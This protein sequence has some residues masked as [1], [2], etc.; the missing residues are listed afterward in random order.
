PGLGTLTSALLRRFPR[1]W[2]IEFDQNL[3]KNLP[4]SFPGKDL[5]VVNADFL[6]FDLSQIS[7]PYVVAGNIPYYITS[8]IIT[9]LLTA[10]TP[11]LKIVLL[12]QKEV[13]ERILSAQGKHTYLSI[14]AQ[15]YANIF[16]GSTVP[17][18]YFTPPPKVDSAV[19]VFEPHPP[20]LTEKELK[21]VKA[22]FSNPRKKLIKN[23]PHNREE[24]QTALLKL[25]ISENARPADLSLKNWKSLAKSL[26]II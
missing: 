6:D 24:V 1:V 10:T 11:P 5:K 21:F 14:F 12:M 19:V 26:K 22:S 7:E 3:A 17:R 18:E 16:P 15:N 23:L 25:G 13:A 8:P 4:K 9:K 20:F 2:A